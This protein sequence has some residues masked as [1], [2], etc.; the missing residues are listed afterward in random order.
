M[1]EL[2]HR[3][4][5]PPLHACSGEGRGEGRGGGGVARKK[6]L[7]VEGRVGGKIIFYNK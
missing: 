3:E 7:R 4:P 1:N 2:L 6:E 5:T